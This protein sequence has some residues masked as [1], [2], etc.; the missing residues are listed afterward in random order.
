M[1]RI[2]V[3]VVAMIVLGVF[4]ST[5]A[6]AQRGPTLDT[7][8]KVDE[9][10]FDIDA[11][12]SLDKSNVIHRTSKQVYDREVFSV[13]ERPS[14]T[15][16]LAEVFVVQEQQVVTRSVSDSVPVWVVVERNPTPAVVVE[17]NW[18]YKIR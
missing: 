6:F 4:G 8:V 11:R 7:L 16:P 1:K 12:K 2:T 17:P 3:A 10:R 5:K 9:N 14:P 15:P 18:R 13:R